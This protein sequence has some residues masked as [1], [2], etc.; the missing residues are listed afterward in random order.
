M[1]SSDEE[2]GLTIL[3]RIPGKEEFLSLVVDSFYEKILKDSRV[4][5]FFTKVDMDTLREHQKKFL[6]SVLGGKNRYNGRGLRSAHA[7]LVKDLGLNDEH[8]NAV[9]EDLN[10]VLI[11]MSVPDLLRNEIMGVV[12]KVR[13]DVLGRGSFHY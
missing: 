11:E 1:E 6:V 5:H 7:K 12:G 13:N 8:F 9:A 4:S 10:C 2:L 3:D